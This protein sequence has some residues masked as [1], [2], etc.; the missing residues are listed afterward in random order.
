[1]V[2]LDQNNNNDPQC[3]GYYR[4]NKIYFCN[5]ILMSEIFQQILGKKIHSPQS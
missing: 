3:L 4:A 2:Y 1:M 5:N